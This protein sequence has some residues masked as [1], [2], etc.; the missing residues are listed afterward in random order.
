MNGSRLRKPPICPWVVSRVV[1]GTHLPNAGRS[2]FGE[3]G[4]YVLVGH[5]KVD[6]QLWQYR[7]VNFWA[8]TFQTRGAAVSEK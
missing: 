7:S 5:S 4:V 1:L 3:V 8:R 6:V 2:G